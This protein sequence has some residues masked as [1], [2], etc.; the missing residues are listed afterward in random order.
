M[1]SPLGNTISST[2]SV[3]K[4]RSRPLAALELCAAP[5]SCAAALP[6]WEGCAR[7]CTC[8]LG[9]GPGNK[10]ESM[11]LCFSAEHAALSML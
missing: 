11:S 9:K 1:V 6:D 2:I 3:Y 7:R 8:C 4:A 10:V 5:A